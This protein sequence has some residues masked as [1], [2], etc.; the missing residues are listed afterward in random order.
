MGQRITVML[1]DDNMIKLRNK[2]SKLIKKSSKS[3]SFSRVLNQVLKKA[4]TGKN[5]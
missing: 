2:Q 5:S 1:D 4:L 3:I